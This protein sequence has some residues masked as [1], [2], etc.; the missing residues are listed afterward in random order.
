MSCFCLQEAV[1]CIIQPCKWLEIE[2]LKLFA[3]NIKISF[4]ANTE[5]TEYRARLY[6]SLSYIYTYVYIYNYRNLDNSWQLVDDIYSDQLDYRLCRKS[7]RFYE[8]LLCKTENHLQHFYNKIQ[9][10]S[11]VDKCHF[12]NYYL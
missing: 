11:A 10:S 9:I 8:F 2:C 7:W 5:T 4:V 1:K 12:L 6:I 3:L